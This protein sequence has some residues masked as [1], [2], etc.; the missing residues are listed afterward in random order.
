[1]FFFFLEYGL[2]ESTMQWRLEV[3]QPPIEL[4]VASASCARMDPS[5][6]GWLQ[7]VVPMHVVSSVN[8]GVST[9]PAALTAEQQHLLL[10]KALALAV[11]LLCSACTWQS[12]KTP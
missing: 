7:H 8:L 1:M 5:F 4:H 11:A 9:P 2:S 12:P 10:C 6:R 3:T